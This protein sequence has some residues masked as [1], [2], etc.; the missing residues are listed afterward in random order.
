MRMLF[1]RHLEDAPPCAE[2]G[3]SEGKGDPPPSAKAGGAATAP[4]LQLVSKPLKDLG[5]PCR[6]DDEVHEFRCLPGKDLTPAHF[7]GGKVQSFL[8][9]SFSS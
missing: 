7:K 2:Q 3:A 6:R 9:F 1:E 8:M 4:F 5:V